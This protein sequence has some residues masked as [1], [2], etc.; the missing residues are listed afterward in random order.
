MRRLIISEKNHAA[1]RIALILSNNTLKRRS[2]AGVP[3]FEFA[4]D[5]HDYLVLG[6][7][8]HIVELDYPDKFNDWSAV[9]PKDLIY[10]KPEKKVDPSAKKIMTALKDLAR[11]VDE[12]IVA[13]D[14]D[15]EG[16]LIG[17]EAMQQ[18]DTK[19]P[20]K[21]ARFSALTK[22]EI[23]RAFSELTEV[24]YKLAS[25]A[26]TRQ[27]IDL[28]W[29][30]A[31]TRFISL[32]SGQLG[33][34]FLSVGRVQSPT[35]A[36]VVARE[37]EVREFK[38]TPYWVVS[39]DLKKDTEFRASHKHGSF[40]DREAAQSALTNAKL[41]KTATVKAVAVSEKDEYPPAPF[42]T[43]VFVAEATKRGLTA[44]Q[45][46]KI[47]EDLYTD[48]YISYPRTDNTVY[49]PS[50]SLRSI[51]EKLTKSEFSAEAQ[52]LLAQESIR[53]SK[54]KKSTTDHPPIH[55]VDAA[56][57]AELKG[58]R[59]DIYELVT[60]RFLATVA[61]SCRSESTLVDLDLGGEP[62][63][64]EGYR[65]L[66]PGRRKYYPYYTS[67]D[68]LLPP[69]KE[70]DL[71]EV[72]KALSTEKKTMPPPRFTQGSLIQEME[73]KGLGTKSTR[74]ETIQ[75][76]YDRR[77]AKG[78]KIE[79]T[80][81]GIAVVAALENHARLHDEYKITHAK[82]TAHLESEMDLIAQGERVLEDVLE[83]SQDMLDDIMTVLE[84]NKKEIGADIR[85][86]INAQHALGECPKC[87]QG[88]LIEIR[89]R[90]GNSFAGCSRYPDCRTT[91]PL[92]RGLLAL[93]SD[94]KCDVCG[95]PK[96]KLVSR[97]QAPNLVCIDP[98]CE[99][100]KRQR[101]LG[102]CPS[103]GKDIMVI[104]SR[105]GKRFAGCAGYPECRVIYPL[106]QLGKLVPTA[107]SCD[108]C[109]APIVNIWNRPGR[110]PW[111][112]CINMECPKRSAKN[113]AGKKPADAK[114]ADEAPAAK[115]PPAKKPARK[116][117][118]AK[119][120]K[121]V[122]IPSEGKPSGKGATDDAASDKDE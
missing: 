69:L 113:G 99:G 52:E 90:N 1:L 60:R 72:L 29:G 108:A 7:R 38:P 53:A 59:W 22:W 25:A 121:P 110:P 46:M 4:R 67:S 73:R 49:P 28:V 85:N 54:G 75:K 23:E 114:P 89:Q 47:A 18:A 57:R 95:G 79:P 10:A 48:G 34:D 80:E 122:E 86:A 76:L 77:F 112:L 87:K 31:L 119:K 94:E 105:I 102:K 21:R 26:E 66:F 120:K 27:L 111:I 62:F 92:P 83:E 104:Q 36:L 106:P 16:E 6:L 5:G 70:G 61:P 63:V 3:V 101:R 88:Q 30:A 65:I 68:T 11:G 81:S 117:A 74:H 51:L 96:I 109:G 91:Y 103:C 58:H 93:P 14:F 98:N 71:P 41:A 97:G 19:K 50:L 12:V 33:K 37:K 43:T 17:V 24:D 32:A 64:S 116:K 100:S 2:V 118:S 39:A 8:G 107:Q 35:L 55:P 44:S 9:S 20:L 82:M 15:R 13:T 84:K 40:D 42:N 115:K 78:V 45:A 56:T